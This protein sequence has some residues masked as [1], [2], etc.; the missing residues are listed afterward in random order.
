V[1]S[2]ELYEKLSCLS[3]TAK[4]IPLYLLAEG[5]APM[6]DLIKLTGVKQRQFYRLIN[7][8]KGFIYK[9][10]GLFYLS[11]MT[12]V[13]KYD[14]SISINLKDKEKPTYLPEVIN[15]SNQSLSDISDS[16]TAIL[17]KYHAGRL[18]SLVSKIVPAEYNAEVLDEI[19]RYCMDRYHKGLVKDLF[20]YVESCIPEMW[21]KTL[22]VIE[23]RRRIRE[24]MESIS[25]VESMVE[26]NKK[27]ES[28][29]PAADPVAVR[30]YENLLAKVKASK[31]AFETWLK[32]AVPVGF[33][34]GRIRLSVQNTFVM[35]MVQKYLVGHDICFEVQ[36]T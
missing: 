8:L 22:F 2:L 25:R 19:I 20:K 16:I 10:K 36:G 21:E 35:Q 24:E 12:P 15:T 27:T 11:K 17:D 13:C 9:K 5:P 1:I 30:S 3:N 18:F 14:Q 6:E 32:T 34:E 7:E 26:E 31:A 29:Y 4:L 33:D 28:V 23:D